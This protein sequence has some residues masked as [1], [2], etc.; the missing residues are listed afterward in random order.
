ME[1]FTAAVSMAVAVA[2][3]SVQLPQTLTGDTEKEIMRTNNL[4]LDG[5]KNFT[6]TM[7]CGFA[8]VMLLL[9]LS[10]WLLLTGFAGSSFAQDLKPRMFASPGA[11]SEALFQAVQND[12][13]PA[14]DAIL[15]AGKDV[16]SSGD[17]LQDKTEREQFTEKYQEMHRLVREPDG[18]TLLYV[19][20]ENWPFPIPLISKDDKW[21]FDSDRGKQEIL[22]RRIGE[23]EAIAIQVCQE[24]AMAK[25]AAS[26]KADSEDPITR[27]A[28][29]LASASAANSD[30]EPNLFR[31]YSFRVL[32]N[33][34]APAMSGSS[35]NMPVALVAYP[36]EY[37]SS[38][39][40]T[41]VVTRDGI[42][43]ERDRGAR[44]AKL[45]QTLTAATLS[46][47]HPAE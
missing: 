34:S 45:A 39:V 36:V 7:G 10:G 40:M 47:W 12:D 29:S 9:L 28:E 20:A 41:F 23:N 14:L 43:Y 26:A 32:A 25:N 8:S 38:G 24:F 11:A 1:G 3:N 2:G 35:T 27:F 18:N 17:D 4:K 21:Y 16:T 22:Y 15:G 31:G 37:K 30:K 13:E 42:V 6:R 33:D 5:F 46:S 19:G 44:T